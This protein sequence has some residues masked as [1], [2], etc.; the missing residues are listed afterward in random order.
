MIEGN[1]KV[2]ISGIC[3]QDGSF[4][5]ELL[6]EKGY[7][8]HGIVRRSAVENYEHR[9]SRINHI[10]DKITLHGGDI[11][12]YSSVY[13]IVS[14]VMPD[15]LYHLAAQSFVGESFKDPFTVVDTNIN[16][17]LNVLEA[18]MALVP[19]CKIYFAG[20]SEMFG[21][22]IETPQT[23]STPFYPRSPYGVSK[24]TGFDLMRNYRESYDMFCCSGILFNH[25]GPRRGYEFITRKISSTVARIV[26][27]KTKELRVGNIE[28]KRDFGSA[29]DYVYAMY[30]M[31]QHDTPDD[32]V[33]A[34]GETHS[35]KEI[36]Q[37]AFDYVN[38]KWEDYVVIDPQ[39]Y[40]PAEVDILLGDCTKAKTILGWKPT[41]S[42]RELVESMVDNDLELL[43][44]GY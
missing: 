23:E 34:S 28:S 24:V 16:G 29:K 15:E 21:K 33:I 30:L 5:A 2:I 8:V 32:Y 19:K 13:N 42:F 31:L 27:G 14:K 1:K 22:V 26:K 43:E 37:I 7:E 41:T 6:L 12:N 9:F 20:S 10:L 4:L 44:G 25:T 3:G 39:F 18:A 11:T 38:L 36:L 17:T 40:R 35:I